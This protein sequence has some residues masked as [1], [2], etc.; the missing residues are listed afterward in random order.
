MHFYILKIN[1]NSFSFSF[2]FL[3]DE[4]LVKLFTDG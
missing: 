4:L 3:I 1:P 2:I